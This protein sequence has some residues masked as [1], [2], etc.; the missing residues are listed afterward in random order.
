MATLPPE[1]DEELGRFV[2]SIAVRA[3]PERLGESDA[4]AAE[5]ERLAERAPEL[6]ASK[7]REIAGSSRT[8]CA[9]G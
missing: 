4:F 5:L 7:L 1:R 6:F 2:E 9:N 8:S 3:E